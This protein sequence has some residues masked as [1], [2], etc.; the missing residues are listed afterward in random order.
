M[1]IQPPTTNAS[2][3]YWM[4]DSQHQHW[5]QQALALAARGRY[6]TWPNPRVGCLLVRGGQIVGQGYHQ[7]AGEPHAE[8]FALR[9]AGANARGAT[10][11]VTL[12][13]CSHHGRTPPCADALIEAGVAKVV[14]AMQ[15][16]DP[17][18]SGRGMER[19]RQ[20]G[21]EVITGVAEQDALDLNRG[22][23]SRINRARPWVRLKLACSLDGRTAMA[24]GESQWITGPEARADVH[25]WR[26]AS[27]AVITGS[28]TVL[29]D[30]PQLLARNIDAECR[31]PL[32]LVADSRWRTPA[33]AQVLQAEPAWLVGCGEPPP[34]LAE[35]TRCLSLP[36]VAGRVD[37]A[38][39]LAALNEA[40]IGELLVEAGA[41]LAGGFLQAGLVDELLL[42]QAP[43]LLGHE[44]KPLVNLPGLETLAQAPRFQVVDTLRLGNDLRWRLLMESH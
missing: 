19:L 14:V 24:S 15:D 7:S 6:T 2:C 35:R 41:G 17:R 16:P 27:D 39:L 37:L 23:V 44:A 25:H 32:R 5:M 1:R 4:S 12:E 10:V 22:F 40:E 9:E 8:V 18:V 30:D 42:Y 3:G 11:Y 36:G 20:A 33:N 29:A 31:Q 13:P 34:E 28:G 38:A 26:A 21:I 43:M